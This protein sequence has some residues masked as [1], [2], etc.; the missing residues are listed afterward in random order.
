M[1]SKIK[2]FLKNA[3]AFFSFGGFFLASCQESIVGYELLNENDLP[4]IGECAL[5][6]SKDE[7][8]YFQLLDH[9]GKEICKN[10]GIARSFANDPS[11]Y[12]QQFGYTKKIN[13]D[14]TLL[15]LILA[16]G[17]EKLHEAISLKQTKKAIDIMQSRNLLNI[18]DY[19]SIFDK[20]KI[21]QFRR[22]CINEFRKQNPDS[23]FAADIEPILNDPTS[24]IL[25][26]SCCYLCSRSTWGCSRLQCGLRG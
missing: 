6:L 3:F 20:E 13:L 11:K 7:Q 2:R 23:Q 9:L 24:L 10:P 26:R 14:D 25:T 5:G 18:D 15:R 16:L 21:A 12:L 19:Y 17:D 22:I 8:E 1:M 4:D